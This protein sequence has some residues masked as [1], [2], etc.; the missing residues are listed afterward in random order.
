[1]TPRP[2]PR[3]GL[4]GCGIWGSNIL[5]DLVAL[6][7]EVVVVDPDASARGRARNA[8]AREAVGTVAESGPASGEIRVRSSPRA[9]DASAVAPSSVDGWIVATPASTHADVVDSIAAAGVPILCEKPLAASVA[10][11]ERIVR[12]TR[13]PLHV[14]DVWRYHPAVEKLAD[15]ATECALGDPL[16]L[17]VTRANWTSP[18][19]D[20]D[21]AWN[22]LPHD[23][24]IFTH[25]FGSAPEP[26]SALAEVVDGSARSFWSHWRLQ[27]A[28]MVSEVSNR[29]E[30]RRREIRLHAS[31]GVAVFDAARG[32][33]LLLAE[34]PADARLEAS[35]RRTIQVDATPALRRQLEAWLGFLR[36]GAEP[37]TDVAAG[38]H[39]V[40][41]VARA[42]ELAGLGG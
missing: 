12:A 11:A 34:G 16:G 15:L 13:G 22:L 10:D 42:R 17:R 14:M 2:P 26:V 41:L 1:M 3:I 32:S 29:F 35:E 21:A 38:V 18:R 7:A 6:G 19:T 20:V 27:G 23:V 8:G 37:R 31:A 36:G 24:S 39:T 33:E 25:V 4:L 40:R 28:W 30:T 5:R 9:A